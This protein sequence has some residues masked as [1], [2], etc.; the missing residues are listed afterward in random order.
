MTWYIA[1]KQ[2]KKKKP[3]TT[4]VHYVYFCSNEITQEK[5]TILATTGSALKHSYASKEWA[6]I[7]FTYL[8]DK[9]LLCNHANLAG[10]FVSNNAFS[11]D[12]SAKSFP[13]AP[14]HVWGWKR[15]QG[16][17]SMRSASGQ[18]RHGDE[19]VK[20][21]LNWTVGSE[22]HWLLAYCFLVCGL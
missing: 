22:L 7:Q 8:E 3:S 13:L 21:T 17:N 10:R 19:G 1:V 2:K 14:L 18:M 11:E 9:I 12:A 20:W 15:K 5:L 16:C 6:R 4:V